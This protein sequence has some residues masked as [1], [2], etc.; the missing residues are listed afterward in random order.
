MKAFLPS[1]STLLAFDAAARTGSFTGAARELNMTQSAVS[2][3]V[4]GL[5]EHLGVKLFERRHHAVVLT[6]AGTSYAKDV[7]AALDIILSA[8]LR[9]MANPDG[10]RLNLAVLPTF[11]TRWLMPRLPDFLARHPDVTVNVMSRL[12]PFDFRT[13]GLD[14]AIH[15]GTPDWLGAECTFLRAEEVVP[16]CSP[17]F[18]AAHPVGCARDLATLNR[19]HISSRP[20]DWARWFR[21]QG[22]AVADSPGMLFEQLLTAAQAAAVGLGVALLPTFL[23]AHELE[24]GDLVVAFDQPVRSD[25]AYYLVVPQDRTTHPPTMAF[26][27]WL[28]DTVAAEAG[29]SSGR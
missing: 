25:H 9:L 10:G 2:K 23:I 24:Q 26:R 14:A 7:R 8:S 27:A 22:V 16:I 12:S 29:R 6:A 17:A 1:T 4:I 18:L 28:L 13:A 19:L 15:F 5:E 3:Q 20:D 11:G 21:Q